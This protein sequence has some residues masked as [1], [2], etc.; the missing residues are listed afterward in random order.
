MHPAKIAFLVV[1][2]L[3]LVAG[4]GL[5]LAHDR[6]TLRAARAD[7]A[8]R[9]RHLAELA[10]VHPLVIGALGVSVA[11]G[12][13][14]FVLDVERYVTSGLFWIKM[15]LLV[16]LIG[17]AIAMQVAERG[18]RE[19]GATTA[20]WTRLR[21]TALASTVLWALVAAAGTAVGQLR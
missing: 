5:A 10:A 19:D 1:H 14:L 18:L 13:V 9:A 12:L 7:D 11:S 16:G 15:A 21:G 2:V 4:G 3:A 6:G 17:N 8:E 20:G